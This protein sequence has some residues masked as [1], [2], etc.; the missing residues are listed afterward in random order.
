LGVSPSALADA[1]TMLLVQCIGAILLGWIPFLLLRK[2]PRRWWFY[3][4]LV[5]MPV[6][7]LTVLITP[8]WIAPLFITFGPMKDR[9]L[10]ASIS[11]SPSVPASRA[12]ACS[13]W[14]RVWTRIPSMRM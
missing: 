8:I 7:V 11:G 4:G 9:S 14:T 6:L 1:V 5:A 13:K 3:T 2:S 10:E 12:A